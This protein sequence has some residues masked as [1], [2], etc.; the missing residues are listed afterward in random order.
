MFHYT[1]KKNIPS[2]IKNGL[3]VNSNNNLTSSS[4]NDFD[5]IYEKFLGI[6]KPLFFCLDDTDNFFKKESDIEIVVDLNKKSLL[7]DIQSLFDYGG[8]MSDCQEY[9]L[10]KKIDIEGYKH[11]ENKNIYISDLLSSDET[12]EKSFALEL[13]K[14]GIYHKNVSVLDFKMVRE[15]EGLGL[16][17]NCVESFDENG[18]CSINMFFDTT[19]FAFVEESSVEIDKTRFQNM[20]LVSDAKFDSLFKPSEQKFLICLENKDRGIYM[21]YNEDKDIHYF[22]NHHRSS[23]INPT[24]RNRRKIG[25]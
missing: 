23:T 20:T 2:I 14:T 12:E 4:G 11:L 21:I 8:E 9:F 17:G 10:F 3:K 18:I 22:F 25:F 1:N 19:D 6:K 24:L 16:Q 7:A 15:I 13:T 5:F